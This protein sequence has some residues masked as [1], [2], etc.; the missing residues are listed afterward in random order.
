MTAIAS[1]VLLGALVAGFVQGLSG[2]AFG[3]VAM[4][5]WAWVLAPQ[6]AGP[7]VVFGSL[8][9]QL[10]AIGA[11]RRNLHVRRLWPFVLGG[12]IGT[13]L[14]VAML[15]IIDPTMFKLAVGLILVAYCP[16]LLLLRDIPRIT[17]G[18]RVA[19]GGIGVIGGFM[20]GLGGLNGPAPTLWCALRGWSR[21]E[22]RSVY[23]TYSLCMQA[24]ALTMYATSGLIDRQ[25]LLLFAIMAPTMVVPTLLGIRLYARFSDTGFRRLILLLLSLSGV[26]LLLASAPKLLAR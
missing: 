23:Q 17:F 13:P 14:G 12:C 7:L 2:F 3:L 6:L 1:Y 16:V 10:L 11:M 21:D 8:I 26:V 22:Q 24:L 5:I 20:G 19:D 9:G 15:H 25:T 18:G 4:T